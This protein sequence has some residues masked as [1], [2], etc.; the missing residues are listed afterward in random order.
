MISRAQ[1]HHIHHTLGQKDHIH[2]ILVLARLAF[3]NADVS[4]NIDPPFLF[5]KINQSDAVF[6]YWRN[7]SF[8]FG[9]HRL[10]EFSSK[11]LDLLH[12]I[13][14]APQ[15][16]STNSP[17]Q[18]PPF[19]YSFS[20]LYPNNGQWSIS[21]IWHKISNR[22]ANSSILSSILAS[23]FEFSYVLKFCLNYVLLRLSQFIEKIYLENYL[24]EQLVRYQEWLKLLLS[25]IL[26]F[27]DIFNST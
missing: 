7:L 15:I 24:L 3:A 10:G 27:I 17:L 20:F 13:R 26:Y 22:F 19:C 14:S 8:T 5:F 1:K 6:Q 2:H 21:E 9:K 11:D 16:S 23:I 18:I 4:Y 25:K 12:N